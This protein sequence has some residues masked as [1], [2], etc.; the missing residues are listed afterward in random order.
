MGGFFNRMRVVNG[1]L[2][3][4]MVAVWT[5]AASAEARGRTAAASPSAEGDPQVV[6][7]V[8]QWMGAF[9]KRDVAALRMLG[10]ATFDEWIVSDSDTLHKNIPLESALH[11]VT[12]YRIERVA[13]LIPDQMAIAN[14]QEIIEDAPAREWEA[15]LTL[16]RTGAGGTWQVS[17]VSHIVVEYHMPG[18]PDG[19]PETVFRRDEE[20]SLDG[21][22]RSG[23]DPVFI[24]V[25]TLR[26]DTEPWGGGAR[27]IDTE[28]TKCQM[29][30][31]M[32]V[33]D[34]EWLVSA[35]N[36]GILL[37][38]QIGRATE[39]G[40]GIMLYDGNSNGRLTAGGVRLENMD[41]K[42]GLLFLSRS[43][44]GGEK[45]SSPPVA[46]LGAYVWKGSSLKNIWNF[47]FMRK[48]ASFA[49]DLKQGEGGK[50]IIA[51]LQDG[52]DAIGCPDGGMISW[53]WTG[54]SFKVK[55]KAK[56]GCT[57]TSWPGEGGILSRNGFSL[58]P[59][60]TP[61]P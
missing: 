32:V 50:M 10:A 27:E 34:L 42:T 28:A 23:I 7:V 41:G 59:P 56:G 17:H 15:T 30:P 24:R 25:F 43:Y 60:S 1:L 4:L 38:Q 21:Y 6:A 13:T 40:G 26:R 20:A 16:T 22:L 57:G 47:D 19:C 58:P 33:Q 54:S 9:Q 39:A 8:N 46:R 51:T 45:S 5:L 61:S 14:V 37:T 31:S 18:Y 29:R 12:E 55:D 3:L 2:V 44:R 49:V 52:G 11:P 53:Q 36:G 35:W 48:G